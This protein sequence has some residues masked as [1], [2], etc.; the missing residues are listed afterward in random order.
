MR[1]KYRLCYGGEFVNFSFSRAW[2]ILDFRRGVVFDLIWI[3]Y[4]CNSLDFSK[5]RSREAIWGG[6]TEREKRL[7]SPLESALVKLVN[8]I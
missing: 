6:P 5:Q 3:F 4:T 2:E 8:L 1:P 7:T